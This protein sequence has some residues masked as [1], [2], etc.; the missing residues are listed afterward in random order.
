MDAH[1]PREHIALRCNDPPCMAAAARAGIGLALLPRFLVRQQPELVAP[2]RPHDAPET[3]TRLLYLV[4]H[5]DIRKTPRVR[6]AADAIAAAFDDGKA[7][8]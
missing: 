1:I 5:V 2:P 6:A 7:M 8:R 4:L 3:P